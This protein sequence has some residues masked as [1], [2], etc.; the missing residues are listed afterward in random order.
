MALPF[1]LAFTFI[2]GIMIMAAYKT[3]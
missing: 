2:L 1:I 3:D